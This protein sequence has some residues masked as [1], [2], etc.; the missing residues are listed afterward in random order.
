M[1]TLRQLPS[2]FEFFYEL[3]KPQPAHEVKY[4]LK[5]QHKLQQAQGYIVPCTEVQQIPHDAAEADF[6]ICVQIPVIYIDIHQPKNNPCRKLSARYIL[7]R[8][9]QELGLCVY[10]GCVGI[11]GADDYK[12]AFKLADD[13]PAALL[14][15]LLFLIGNVTG[16]D[17]AEVE[18][19]SH[20][21]RLAPCELR[22]QQAALLEKQ[23][24]FRHILKPMLHGRDISRAE[25][26]DASNVL[27]HHSPPPSRRQGT[28]SAA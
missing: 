21:L 4:C 24:L 27:A 23:P 8:L 22:K 7:Q 11:V 10:L 20:F 9:Y 15:E 19:I 12:I 26:Y 16:H 28:A 5:K 6:D 18:A 1:L 3:S 14:V 2:V 25:G 17:V 13:L